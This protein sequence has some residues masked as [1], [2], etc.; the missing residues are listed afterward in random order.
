MVR[1]RIRTIHFTT[2][3]N[4]LTFIALAFL[5][6]ATI[7]AFV[8]L[9]FGGCCASSLSSIEIPELV[10]GAIGLWRIIVSSTQDLS[11]VTY[12]LT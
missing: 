6:S 11:P 7:S 5:L 1:Y 4:F 12:G 3:E 9:A 2:V 8:G 10:G